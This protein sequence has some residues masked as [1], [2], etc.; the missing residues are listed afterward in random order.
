M[1]SSQAVYIKSGDQPRAFNFGNQVVPVVNTTTVQ[2]SLP[3]YKESVYSTF[4]AIVSGTGAVTATVAIQVT[5]DDNTG[6]GFILNNMVAP[7]V[8][9]TTATGSPTL[10]SQGNQ[11]TQALVGAT[12]SAPGVPV[13]TT[14]T[15]VAANGVSATMSANATATATVPCIFYANNWC[16]TAMGTITLSGTTINADGFTTAAPWRYVR[17]NITA[18][19]GTGAAVNVLMGV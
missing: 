1:A 3:I 14:I 6:R 10:V 17:A 5:N 15:A 16:T 13:G 4:Q 2:A 9:V 19:S 18:I 12:T 11:F 7:G 8:L